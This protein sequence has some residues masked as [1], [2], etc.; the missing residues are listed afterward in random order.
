M[1][2]PIQPARFQKGHFSERLKSPRRTQYSRRPALEFLEN[3]QLL[4]ASLQPIPPPTV[5]ELQGLA[6]PLLANNGATDPQTFTVTSSNPDVVVSIIQGG[7]WNITV[8]YTDPN[9]STNDFTGTLTS[10]LFESDRVGG[11]GP[12][13]NLATNTVSQITR[14]TMDNY[15]TNPTVLPTPPLPRETNPTKTFSRIVGGFPNATSFVVQGG[16]PT[17]YGTGMSGQTGTPFN[18]ENFQQLAFSGAYQLALANAGITTNDTQ[19][20][21]TTGSPNSQ[22]GYNYPI[23]GQLLTGLPTLAKMTEVP[24]TTNPAFHEDSL[25]VNPISMTAVSLTTANPNGVLLIDTTQAMQGETATISVTATDTVD[26]TTASQSF[27]VS[28]GA[29]TGPTTSN[30]I[31]T[32]NFKPF[33]TGQTV[34]TLPNTPAS[35]QL[36]GQTGS[37]V[38][39]APGTPS[40]T[41]VS[42]PEHGTITNFNAATG[43]LTYTPNAGYSGPD[44]FQYTVTA[45][46][47]NTSAPAAVSNPGEVEISVAPPVHV[48]TV[49]VLE[50]RKHQVTGIEVTF[51]G[52]VNAAEAGDLSIYQ[53]T[54]AGKGGSFTARNAVKIRSKSVVYGSA[55]FTV[56]LKPRKP[57]GL[58]RKVLLQIDGVPPS[59][60]QDTLGRYLDGADTGQSGS[61]ADIVISRRGV[62]IP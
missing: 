7:F 50:N 24:V 49:T 27:T 46:G 18:N 26:H 41:L 4:T 1:Q 17:I 45:T 33:A 59:G 15:Y 54:S 60:L 13:I 21:I 8:S 2:D 44:G 35:V 22:L 61:D 11:N 47:P 56:L 23:F 57:F 36:Q 39:G 5:S 14:Y 29:Y 51:S 30:L 31:Q 40:Y 38:S 53:L 58:S 32:I 6:V 34:T 62:S 28:V 55:T 12:P 25:P 16:G 9:N 37:P 48:S 43:S 19:F 52:A 3:R 10:Q 20:F 42:L